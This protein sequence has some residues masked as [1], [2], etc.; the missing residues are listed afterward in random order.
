M[1]QRIVDGAQA[2]DVQEIVDL[3]GSVTAIVQTSPAE[4]FAKARVVG[5]NKLLVQP[6]GDQDGIIVRKPDAGVAARV[7]LLILDAFIERLAY[8]FLLSLNPVN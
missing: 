7:D 8:R 4:D 2:I 6:G 1:H 5:N 3:M